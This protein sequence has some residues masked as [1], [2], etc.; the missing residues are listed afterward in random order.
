MKKVGDG[1]KGPPSSKEGRRVGLGRR[2]GFLPQLHTG[3]CAVP[4]Q[5]VAC[6]R[7][8]DMYVQRYPLKSLFTSDR[9]D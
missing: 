2:E 7:G 4:A 3:A 1:E 8:Q 5:R 9:M 6:S